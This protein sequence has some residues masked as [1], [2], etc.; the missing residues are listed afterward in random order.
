MSRP[1][2]QIIAPDRLEHG[3]AICDQIARISPYHPYFRM[4]ETCRGP[5]LLD[6]H[7]D[8]AAS[9]IGLADGQIATHFGVW[10]FRMRIGGARVRVGGIGAVGTLP[11]FRRRGLM[12]RT[13]DASLAAM[14]WRGYDLSVLFGIS[15]FYHRFGY[16]RAWATTDTIVRTEDL[17]TDAPLVRPKRFTP[18]H[19]DDL[20]ALY[21]RQHATV[22]G[23]AVRPTYAKP[24]HP[25]G[26]WTGYEWPDASG[27][28]AGYVAL[29]ARAGMPYQLVDAAGDPEE[30]LGV[31]GLLCRRW[32]YDEMRLMWL[33]R[34]SPL[35]VRL[36]RGTCRTDVQYHRRGGPMVRT[37]NVCTALSK[38]ASEL[39]RRLKRSHLSGWRGKLL[40]SDGRDRA[41]L[42]IDRSAV[43]VA[44][45]TGTKHAIRGGDAI[46]Q[47]LIGTHDPFETADAAGVRFSGDA[48]RLLPVLFPAQHPQMSYW[49]MF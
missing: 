49:D 44:P 15:D 4:L 14:R 22:T 32:R 21:N 12:R 13:I 11:A 23:T 5:Y 3:E 39:S 7:Y 40:V 28:V 19:R 33:P 8:W 6:A 2:L 42:S 47:L 34:E 20:A 10:D 36:R 46:A 31:L 18:R 9:R 30:V 1:Q 41:T 16:V 17:P 27:Q 29:F 35:A 43:S 48:R 25:G 24:W 45:P 26:R 38:M 37:V